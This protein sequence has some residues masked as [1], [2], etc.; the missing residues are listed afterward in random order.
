MRAMRFQGGR[1]GISPPEHASIG[2]GKLQWTLCDADGNKRCLTTG[3][4]LEDVRVN[5]GDALLSAQ[6]IGSGNPP[7]KNDA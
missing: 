5:E 3:L 4:R 7:P 6:P 2:E 1:S